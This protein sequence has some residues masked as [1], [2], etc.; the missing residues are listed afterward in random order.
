MR[1]QGSFVGGERGSEQFD[2]QRRRSGRSCSRIVP[3]ASWRLSDGRAGAAVVVLVP[4]AAR[5]ADTRRTL[6]PP[7]RR[8]D[9]AHDLT[10]SLSLPVHSTLTSNINHQGLTRSHSLQQL[11]KR[12]HGSSDLVKPPEIQHGTAAAAG[13]TRTV[14]LRAACNVARSIPPNRAQM[15]QARLDHS[16]PI[17]AGGSGMRSA[18]RFL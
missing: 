17:H 11:P 13:G 6:R 7:Q 2:C 14:R 15:R 1:D 10:F 12:R 18:D 16:S 9:C 3:S 4:P 8:R 5:D